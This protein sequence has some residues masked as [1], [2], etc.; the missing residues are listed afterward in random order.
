MIVLDSSAAVE[1]ILSLPKCRPIEARLH[2]AD[3]QISA[4]QLLVVEVLQVLRRRVAADLTSLRQA[5]EARDL[6]SALPIYYVDHEI[7]AD[8]I[9]QLRDN[10]TAYDASFVVLAERLGAE[11]VTCDE[12]LAHAPG[13]SATVYIPTQSEELSS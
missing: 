1:L 5:E 12:K 7:S 3:W 4:P 10:L 8:S 6:F 2:D 13:H 9:W 11:L